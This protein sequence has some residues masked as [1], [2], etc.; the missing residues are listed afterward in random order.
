MALAGLMY[1][2]MTF[3]PGECD[4]SVMLNEVE[5][6]YPVGRARADDGH[7]DRLRRPRRRLV[8]GLHRRHAGG[9]RR[10]DCSS[11]AA[12]PIQAS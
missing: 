1:E 10:Y 8:D 9:D 11:T 6:E 5:A 3:A 12:S 7:P 4:L 2:K